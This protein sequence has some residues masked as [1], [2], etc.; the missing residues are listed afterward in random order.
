MDLPLPA[1][2]TFSTLPALAQLTF[3][4]AMYT[5]Q[6]WPPDVI[7]SHRGIFPRRRPG[8]SRHRQR[9]RRH[10]ARRDASTLPLSASPSSVLPSSVNPPED[11]RHRRC[12][13]PV[14]RHPNAFRSSAGIPSRV[15]WSSSTRARWRPAGDARPRS[16][17]GALAPGMQSS[18]LRDHTTA[19]ATY[20]RSVRGCGRRP[21]AASGLSHVG[22]H[23]E[24]VGD[25]NDVNG[26]DPVCSFVGLTTA[27]PCLDFGSAQRVTAGQSRGAASAAREARAEGPTLTARRHARPSCR[28]AARGSHSTISFVYFVRDRRFDVGPQARQS[29]ACPS[30]R[31]PSIDAV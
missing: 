10:A 8:R 4:P 28:V 6:R 19:P 27:L 24:V 21:R 29:H 25:G 12:G 20:V 22:R 11:H 31:T 3:P 13:W 9:R 23:S 15:R 1:S 14:P 26:Q 18:A 17:L 16:R 30:R 2:A 5:P 7:L